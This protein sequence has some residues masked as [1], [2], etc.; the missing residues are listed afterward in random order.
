MAS[1]TSKSRFYGLFISEEE[2]FL[3]LFPGFRRETDINRFMYNNEALRLQK[4]KLRL[5][6]ASR[7][8]WHFD[9]I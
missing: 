3:L 1:Y 4:H 5:C 6:F 9:R 7:S 2:H 8:L